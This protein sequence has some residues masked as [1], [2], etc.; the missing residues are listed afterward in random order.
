MGESE[1]IVAVLAGGRAR[2]MGGAKASLML[3]GRPLISYPLAAAA[4]AGLPAIVLAKRSTPLPEL[5]VP[6]IH[7]P[8][9]PV[10]PL[11][12]VL[13]ALEH[14][15][16]LAPARA[17]VIVAC[18]MP[19]LTGELLAWLARLDGP[20]M[21]ALDGLPQPMLAR[22][23]AAHQPALRAALASQ[24]ALGAALSSLSP[25]LL[26]RRQL[27]AFGEPARLL[28]NVNRPQDLLRAERLAG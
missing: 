6:V 3:G 8:D 22:L 7:E 23:E 9:A 12:G 26:G 1:A 17:V 16:G 11:C 21:A 5:A 14:A 25:R 24:A 2:R 4:D 27:R 10:H 15:A 13:A 28:F 18:D 19:F 20:A